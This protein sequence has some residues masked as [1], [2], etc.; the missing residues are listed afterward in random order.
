MTERKDG[1]IPEVK[2][3]VESRAE[4]AETIA[5]LLVIVDEVM[6]SDAYVNRGEGGDSLSFVN[7][8]GIRKFGRRSYFEAFDEKYGMAEMYLLPPGVDE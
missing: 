8:I 7:R 2:S 4:K 6:L 3:D 5:E 1:Y